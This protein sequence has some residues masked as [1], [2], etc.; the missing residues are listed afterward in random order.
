MAQ[1][2]SALFFSLATMAAIAFTLAMLRGEWSRIVVILSGQAL[3]EARA[4]AA[5]Q[6]RFRQRAW[7]RAER[8]RSSSPLRAA[9]A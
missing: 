4:A 5:P 8:R 1:L 2:F 7:N 6:V 9:A 3:Q